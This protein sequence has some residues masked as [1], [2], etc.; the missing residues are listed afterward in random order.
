MGVISE[1]KAAL[2]LTRELVSYLKKA[3]EHDPKLM[4]M[5]EDLR[6]KVLSLYESDIELRQQV[7]ELEEKVKLRENT[8]FN[9]KNGAYY[10]GTPEDTKDG[11]FC[12]KCFHEKEELVPMFED[13]YDGEYMGR[14]PVCKS[15]IG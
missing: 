3:G 8:F 12:A 1:G 4:G 11:P 7:R 5:F 2:E 15:V 9:R 14:C 6:E 13:S 10:I